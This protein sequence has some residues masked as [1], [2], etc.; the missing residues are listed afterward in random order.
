MNFQVKENV[1]IC[2]VNTFIFIS[3]QSVAQ[4]VKLLCLQCG[5]SGSTSGSGRSPGGAHGTHS[6]IL[7]WRIPWTEEPGG[8]QS[9]DGRKDLDMTEQLTH[10]HSH[11]I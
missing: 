6:T 4:T 9:M 2:N 1:L 3:I 8:L 5:R 10:T 7:A 11:K